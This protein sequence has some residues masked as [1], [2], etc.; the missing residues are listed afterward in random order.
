MDTTPYPYPP[1]P[2]HIQEHVH[3]ALPIPTT[4]YPYSRTW[5]LN[6]IRA[7]PQTTGDDDGITFETNNHDPVT[8]S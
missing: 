7:V 6:C 3:Y 5:T 2:T 4:P 1:R 8:Q